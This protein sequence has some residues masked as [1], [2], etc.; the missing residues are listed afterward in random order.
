[1]GKNIMFE[2]IYLARIRLAYQRPYLSSIIY[3]MNIVEESRCN[4]IA[5]DK[6]W[7]LYYNPEY[8]KSI[9]LEELTGIFYHEVLH[10]IRSHFSRGVAIN[11]NP[12]IWNIAA[13]C[14]IND[15]IIE[16]IK[17]DNRCKMS[18]TEDVCHPEKLGL[19][20]FKSA[21]YYYFKI[22]NNES[23]NINELKRSVTS[24]NCGSASGGISGDYELGEPSES[25]PGIT[26]SNIS[27]VLRKVAH[28][29]KQYTDSPRSRGVVPG[30]LL[31]VVDLILSPP[32]VKWQ[33][34]LE[35]QLRS[36]VTYTIGY[37]DFSYSKRSSR[38][39]GK[40]IFPG[41]RKPSINIVG[42]IDSSGSMSN[43][44]ISNILIEINGI[45]KKVCPQ[46]LEIYVVDSKIHFKRKI[47]KVESIKI[48]G[49]GGTDMTVGIQAA[50][51]SS[52]PRPDIIIVCTDGY[53]PFP[54]KKPHI[55]I[56]VCLIGQYDL[57]SVPSWAKIVEVN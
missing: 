6:H 38:S 26:Q 8:C 28:D 47:S 36:T 29:I 37:Q 10:L 40:V 30:H 48:E 34:V 49:G 27:I 54:K 21:E 2:L 5:V 24:G 7:R 50:V 22:M 1:M 35:T 25:N 18:L 42:I 57:S 13:D 41:L 46:N 20:L 31:K 52:N 16:E 55:P 19:E 15:D 11:A 33:K 32:K 4:T 17:Q 56:I 3:S 51:T 53:T 23:N 43:E 14:E 9:S 39:S 12:S 44:D 45:I